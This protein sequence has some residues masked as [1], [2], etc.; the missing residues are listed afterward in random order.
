MI[1]AIKS[2]RKI[3]SQNGGTNG[4]GGGSSIWG[5]I[6]GLLS[7]Q[8]DLQDALDAKENTLGF[9]PENVAN[10]SIDGTLTTNSDILYPSQKAVKTY[11]DAS[12]TGILDDRGNYT[13]SV[14]SPGPWPTTGGSGPG[15]TILKGD[16]WFCANNGFLGTV[17]VVTGA[18]FRA[19]VD[20]PGQTAGNWNILNVGL[21]YT[22]ENI[23]NK[24]QPNGYAGLDAN[25]K[26]VLSQIPFIPP[27]VLSTA[28]A[29]TLAINVTLYDAVTITALATTITFSITGVAVDFQKLTIRIKDNGT[30]KAITWPGT[31]IN[32]GAVLPTTTTAGKIVS[33]GV[34]YN[35][36]LSTWDCVAV[37]QEV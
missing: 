29:S 25:S 2:I 15:G 27:R 14:T 1:S 11:V 12:V 6:T 3:F 17:A 22:P 23:A 20:S 36:A 19:I 32:K 4:G 18:S 31:F 34:I 26:I 37:S 7:D 9:T 10:K 13:P 35:S 30:A 21:G 33:V 5:N 16:I 8:E 28:T 24:N